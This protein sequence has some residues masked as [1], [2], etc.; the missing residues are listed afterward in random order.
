MDRRVTVRHP[1]SRVPAPWVRSRISLAPGAHVTL[2]CR[3]VSTKVSR[4]SPVAVPAGTLVTAAAALED[5]KVV[6]APTWVMVVVV[7]DTSKGAAL[8]PAAMTMTPIDA[9]MMLFHQRESAGR[10]RRVRLPRL[11]GPGWSVLLRWFGPPRGLCARCADMSVS[12]GATDATFA[13]G[14]RMNLTHR[15]QRRANSDHLDG[16]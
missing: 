2:E 9:P 11:R 1:A 7:V 5:S 10:L 13:T 6:A 4:T 12:L 15:R 8:M 16:I 14:G 3:E